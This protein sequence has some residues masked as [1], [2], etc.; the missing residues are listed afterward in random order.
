MQRK[1]LVKDLEKMR[2]ILTIMSFTVQEFSE[3]LKE[4]KPAE[5]M[6]WP[7]SRSRRLGRSGCD[8][9]R[10]S[11]LYDITPGTMIEEVRFA[12]AR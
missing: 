8:D 3:I 4:R 2:T 6:P 12:G 7:K 10:H 5:R 9:G 11:G 1:N